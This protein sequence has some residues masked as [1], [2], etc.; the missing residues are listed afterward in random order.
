MGQLSQ[1]KAQQINVTRGSQGH[2][3]PEIKQQS[4]LEQK[5]IPVAG[6]AQAV[7]QAFQRITRQHPGEI[8]AVSSGFAE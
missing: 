8:K 5:V 2:I 1:A 6:H 7:Q 4:A 3:K